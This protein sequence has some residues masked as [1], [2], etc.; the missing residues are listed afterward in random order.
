MSENKI[1]CVESGEF[2][3]RIVNFDFHHKIRQV[4]SGIGYCL[5]LTENGEVYFKGKLKGYDSQ[6]FI[7]IETNS[8]IAFIAS[9]EFFFLLMDQFNQLYIYGDFGKTY[10]KLTESV[11]IEDEIKFISCGADIV[12]F[13]TQNNELIIGGCVQ[14]FDGF[15]ETLNDFIKIDKLPTKQIKDLQCGYYHTIILDDNGNVFGSGENTRGQLATKYFLCK[16]SY[17]F[18]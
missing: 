9:G 2:E 16:F 8:F 7:K 4:A 18:L 10:S 11:K 14:A 12:V 5:I 6:D 1:A 15:A 3:K 13:V 17:F